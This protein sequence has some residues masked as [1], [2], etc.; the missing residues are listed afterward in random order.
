MLR[1]LLHKV[2]F[3]GLAI[4]ALGAHRADAQTVAPGPYYAVPSWDMTL[5][6][7][8]RFIVLS[9][10]ASQAVL[11]RETGL[12]WQQSPD[13]S[14]VQWGSAVVQCVQNSTT[15]G[16]R[17][18]W[19]LPTIAELASLND[20]STGLLP[21]GHPFN[22]VTTPGNFYWS[23]TAYP[24]VPSLA[25]IQGFGGDVFGGADGKTSFNHYWCVRGGL[26]AGPF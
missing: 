13:I 18:G 8:T 23:S 25:F 9:N 17:R 6:V 19:R 11:D 12:V 3:I 5:P 22:A 2:S 15:T 10:M 26:G 21:A 14:R 16:G 24:D 1:G 4:I 20:P 7:G